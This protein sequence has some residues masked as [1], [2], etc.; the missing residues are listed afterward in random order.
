[1][2]EY[3][4]FYIDGQWTDPAQSDTFEV[5]NPATEEVAGTVSLGSSADVDKAVAA[6]R[7][8]FPAWS[9]TSREERLALLEKIL[10]VYQRRMGDIAAALTEEMGAPAALASGFQVNLGL[11]HLTTAIEVLR[12]FVFEEQRG[13]SLVVKEPI[14]VCGL[15]TPWNWPISLISVKVFPALAT[16]CTMVLKPSEQS[17]FN[18]QVFAEILDEAG[19]PAGVFNLVQG[20]GPGVGRALSGHP[21]VDLVSFTGSTRAG[22]DVAANAAAGVKRV[23]QELGGKG[24]NII[25]DDADFAENVGKG[26]ATMMMNSGQTCSAPS[27]M[28]VP[29]ERMEE[30]IA[31]AREAASKVT[32]GDPTGDAAIGPVVSKAQFEKV[33][34]LIQRGIDEGATLV[35]GGVGRPE[36][37]TAGYFVQPTVFADV[38]NDMTIAREEIFGPVLTILGYDSIDHAIEIANDTDYGLAGFVAGTDLELA[39]QV[40]RR[41]RVG[42]VAINDAFDFGAPFGG[43]KKSGNGREWGEFGFHDYLEIKGILGYTPEDGN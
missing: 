22:I 27:R 34:G 12:N 26:V 43:Y 29:G 42:N 7:R 24:P 6:A 14:G 5:I 18:G 38:K 17:P 28:L 1:M 31:A 8:A 19:V 20:D 36:G 35:A 4:K 39:R 15:I 32:V 23:T 37:L 40:A 25:L 11:G 9:A 13:G 2:R 33:Q 41:I 3:L 16:G 30:A 10:D 21:D